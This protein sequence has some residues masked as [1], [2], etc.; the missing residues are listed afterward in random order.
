MHMRLRRSSAMLGYLARRA[1]LTV[2]VALA[3][4]PWRSGGAARARAGLA[5]RR[6]SAPADGLLAVV[7]FLVFMYVFIAVRRFEPQ[8]GSENRRRRASSSAMRWPPRSSS[9][10]LIAAGIAIGAPLAEELTFRG[11]IFAALS[12]TRLGFIGTL[13]SPRLPGRRFI[14][15]SRCMRWL[16]LRHGSGTQLSSG[17]LWQPVGADRLPCGVECAS[18]PTHPCC[19]RAVMSLT[20]RRAEPGDAALV[21]GLHPQARGI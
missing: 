16:A 20:I 14:S 2:A 3:C 8:C 4:S 5:N 9:Y 12:Q 6:A 15:P 7:G 19:W 13:C 11:Q 21:L 18:S 10:P 1:L 17:A